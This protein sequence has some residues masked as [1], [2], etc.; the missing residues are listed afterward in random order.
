MSAQSSGEKTLYVKIELLVGTAD[1]FDSVIE[2]ILEEV[3]EK[4]SLQEHLTSKVSKY[5]HCSDFE[6]KIV[7]AEF[8]SDLD[9]S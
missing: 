5:S 9:E 2:G 4:L 1:K 8:L 7:E 6:V 3:R